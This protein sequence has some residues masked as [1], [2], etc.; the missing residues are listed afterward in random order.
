MTNLNLLTHCGANQVPREAILAL[1]EPEP[2]GPRHTPIP[3]SLLLDQVEEQI[4][5]VGLSTIQ[6]VHALSHEGMRYFGMLEVAPT[7]VLDPVP[8]EMNGAI[9]DADY[10]IIL[11][12][13]NAND[14]TF[15]AGLVVGSGVFVCDN[16]CFSGEIKVDRKH[17]PNILKDLP[18]LIAEALQ[19]VAA[20]KDFQDERIAA[21]KQYELNDAQVNDLLI[22]ALDADVIAS[23]KIGQI[24]SE[25]RE[26]RHPEFR[27]AGPT[28]WRLMN[29]FTEVLKPRHESNDLFTLPAK[30][31]QLH[32][33]L[34]GY[35]GVRRVFN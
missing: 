20:L 16:L 19:Q 8:A 1:S 33:L 18:D 27:E 17:T 12:L 7:P 32:V 10:S 3:H 4:A 11:G 5:H 34:D 22:R 28:T 21:Y 30:T 6:E 23:S 13:R 2:S 14:K 15:K 31:E 24:L 26:P 25:W 9:L 35:C 29:A